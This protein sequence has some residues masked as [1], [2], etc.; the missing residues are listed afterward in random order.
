MAN[1]LFVAGLSY[2]S[3][4][5]TL[6]DYFSKAGKVLSAKVIVD[7]FSGRS[8]GFGFVEMSTDEEA[9]KAIKELD[10]TM[11]DSRTIIVREARPQEARPGGG[12]FSSNRNNDRGARREGRDN[13]RSKRW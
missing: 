6:G 1:K 13:K 8:R 9:Q 5:S 7:K 3:T 11:L 4:D 10:N 12:G 2:S